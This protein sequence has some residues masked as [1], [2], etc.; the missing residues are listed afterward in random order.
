MWSKVIE[1][2]LTSRSFVR[3]IFNSAS[4]LKNAQNSTSSTY[5]PGLKDF[6]IAGKTLPKS[7]E[8]VNYLNIH[9]FNGN[10][11]KVSNF[12]KTLLNITKGA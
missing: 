8:A 1:R 3:T 10:G 11:R 2:S 7:T 4:K 9:D 12:H 5:Q 6:L